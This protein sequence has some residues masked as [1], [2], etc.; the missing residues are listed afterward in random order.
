M[1]APLGRSPKRRAYVF[2]ANINHL[3]PQMATSLDSSIGPANV[4]MHEVDDH[5]EQLRETE[6]IGGYAGL[7][8]PVKLGRPS[9]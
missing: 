7:E 8:L 5:H 4:I 6:T 9:I 1:E 3:Y 2:I